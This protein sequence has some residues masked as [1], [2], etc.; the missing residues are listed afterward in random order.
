MTSTCTDIVMKINGTV[1]IA[2]A[3][4]SHPEAKLRELVSLKNWNAFIRAKRLKEL[5]Q[6]N[7]NCSQTNLWFALTLE[8]NAEVFVNF[9][10]LM[11]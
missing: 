8:E 11:E 2:S 6:R 4:A 7:T 5:F 10:Y 1:S 9:D 3:T